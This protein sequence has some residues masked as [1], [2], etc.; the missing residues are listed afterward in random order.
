M[1][2]K[3]LD[4]FNLATA[5]PVSIPAN[6]RCVLEDAIAAHLDAAE[7]LILA[8]DEL[9]G[10][11][12]AEPSIGAHMGTDQRD[13]AA[14]ATDDREEACEDEGADEFALEVL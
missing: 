2:A 5:L 10:D 6:V 7:A 1:T 13:W 4:E 9:D 3:R 8:L 14:G 12:E 11:P